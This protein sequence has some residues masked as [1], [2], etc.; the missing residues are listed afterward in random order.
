MCR[1]NVKVW[2]IVVSRAMNLK[3]YKEWLNAIKS[4]LKS[5]RASDVAVVTTHVL[6][7]PQ[8]VASTRWAFK[9]K[10]DL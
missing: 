3:N 7:I 9:V 8:K 5:T 1:I 6:V 2:A 10:S 4:E